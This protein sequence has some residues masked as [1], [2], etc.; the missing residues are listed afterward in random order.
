MKFDKFDLL[1]NY[2][3]VSDDYK[4]FSLHLCKT[5][6]DKNNLNIGIIG[7][8]GAGK[9][10]AIKTFLKTRPRICRLKDI[11]I[12]LCSFGDNERNDNNFEKE[13]ESTLLQ[14]ILYSKKRYKLPNSRISRYGFRWRSICLILSAI[15]LS[16]SIFINYYNLWASIFNNKWCNDEVIKFVSSPWFGNGVIAIFSVLTFVLFILCYPLKSLIAKI[17][18]IE[19]KAEPNSN[20]TFFDEYL[21]EIIYFFKRTR[22]KLLI[23]EDIDRCSQKNLLL[24]RLHNLNKTLNNCDYFVRKPIRFIYC[25]REDI[26]ASSEEKSKFFDCMISIPP[27]LTYDNMVERFCES[28]NDNEKLIFTV[29]FLSTFSGEILFYRQL[30]NILN[31]FRIFAESKD[32]DEDKIKGL[33]ALMVYKSTF[34]NDYI[35]FTKGKGILWYLSEKLLFEPKFDCSAALKLYGSDNKIDVDKLNIIKDDFNSIFDFY[36]SHFSLI[37]P[38]LLSLIS[39][40]SKGIYSNEEIKM[41]YND[42]NQNNKRNDYSHKYSNALDIVSHKD[43]IKYIGSSNSFLNDSLVEAIFTIKDDSIITEFKKQFTKE[44]LDS[45]KYIIHVIND[46]KNNI[47]YKSFLKMC[48]TIYPNFFVNKSELL[49][50]NIGYLLVDIFTV[51]IFNFQNVNNCIILSINKYKKAF[52]AICSL[53]LKLRTIIIS[54]KDLCLKYFDCKDCIDDSLFNDFIANKKFLGNVDNFTNIL[55]EK[56]IKNYNNALISSLYEA[57]NVNL[58]SYFVSSITDNNYGDY[59]NLISSFNNEDILL[60]SKF[61]SMFT[62]EN[63]FVKNIYNLLPIVFFNETS[64]F[65]ISLTK[66]LFSIKK[67]KATILGFKYLNS[68]PEL[69]LNSNLLCNYILSDTSH[70]LIDLDD[71]NNCPYTFLYDIANSDQA[72]Y[73]NI[74]LVYKKCALS[75]SLDSLKITNDASWKCALD[76]KYLRLDQNL[77][78]KYSN[79]IENFKQIYLLYKNDIL[80]E[81]FIP[82]LFNTQIEFIVKIELNY[83]NISI[84]SLFEKNI[85]NDINNYEFL[86]DYLLTSINTLSKDIIMAYICCTKINMEKRFNLLIK[87][88]LSLDENDLEMYTTQMLDDANTRF[89]IYKEEQNK[90]IVDKLIQISKRTN[91]VIARQYKKYK[92]VVFYKISN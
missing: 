47:V 63:N 50:K 33:F 9:S 24:S 1:Y 41:F 43:C 87:S 90:D 12:S 23:L 36:S 26:F 2:P 34:P 39:S 77:L 28:L 51:G 46:C 83:S 44:N 91:T 27:V 17:R 72:N 38:S 75:G 66:K 56:N 55:N 35:L 6:K 92:K 88:Y 14:Q 58:V 5:L 18:D 32:L 67:L 70:V 76:Y 86:F 7:S 29:D 62:S 59:L 81:N 22:I 30:I 68:V 20:D 60:L 45:E 71:K 69:M 3:K 65:N 78:G 10:S 21:D 61:L 80:A 79:N 73:E 84:I 64:P 54:N 19:I 4:K 52:K 40:F 42:L 82:Q 25:V 57:G 15:C 31:S 13:I 8:F 48:L 11:S 49:D 74:G 89:Q 53:E 85:V 16:F 37:K